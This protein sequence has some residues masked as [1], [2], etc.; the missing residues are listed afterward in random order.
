MTTAQVLL[1]VGV[2]LL[3]DLVV[4]SAVFQFSAQIFNSLGKGCELVEPRAGGVRRDFQTIKVGMFNY[5]AC[6]HIGVD[7]DH[8]HLYPASVV[9]WGGGRAFSV[10]WD[11]VE[12]DA[13]RPHRRTWP[14]RINGQKVHAPAW[15]LKIAAIE[16][17]PGASTG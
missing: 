2:I 17:A 8:L 10:P 15:A 3:V 11:R 12:A 13:S 7:E 16:R 9:R 6:V 14:A 4:V 5:G 1:L